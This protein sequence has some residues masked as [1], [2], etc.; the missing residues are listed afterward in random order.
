MTTPPRIARF[1][2]AFGAIG[3][4][5]TAV[6]PSALAGPADEPKPWVIDSADQWQEF[7]AGSTDVSF[8]DGL[9]KSVEPASTMS[10]RVQTYDAPRKPKSITFSQTTAWNNWKEVPNVGTPDMADA[11]VLVPV[12]PGDY[13]LLARH[14]KFNGEKDGGYHAWHST[15]MKEWT[16]HGPVCGKRERWVTTA[17]VVDGVFYI[18][19]DFPNDED[20]HL[21]IDRDLRDGKMGE[22]KGMAFNDPSHGSDAGV[23]REEDGRFHLFYENWD[24]INAKTHAW[25][26]PLAGRAVSPDGI[27]PFKHANNVV[28]KRTTP[29]GKFGEYRHP[30]GTYK[31]EIHEPE[32][33]AYGDWTSIRIGG[34]YYLFCDYDPVGDHMYVGRWTSDSL[35]KEYTFCGQFGN[36][37]PDPTVGFAEGQFYLIQQRADVDFVS[38]GPWVGGVEARAGVDTTGD[39]AV[40]LWTGWREVKETY[41]QKEG[42]VRL[43]DRTPATLDVSDL[44]AGVGFQFEYRT[45][46]VDGQTVNVEMDRVEW[47]FE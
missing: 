15:D 21:I 36:G 26:S 1:A 39:G 43:V 40:D 14:R 17:E 5:T 47:T 31:Y 4:L 12:K 32:Q 27:Q 18:Y 38:P 23:M 25:D 20:P 37:H 8:A 16:H 9:A 41:K 34:Q 29:T 44:P 28:D 10:S 24:P 46:P 33:N 19:Y 35:E 2:L 13:W 7:T 45:A 42:F 11:P 6:A 22:D 30:H 3:S